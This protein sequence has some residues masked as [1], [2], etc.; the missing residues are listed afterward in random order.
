MKERLCRWHCGRRTSNHSGIC[1]ACWV[2][3]KPLRSFDAAGHAAWTVKKRAKMARG[4]S[5]ARVKAGQ[6]LAARLKA[7]AMAPVLK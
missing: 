5:P 7:R 2:L 6:T 1:D 4:K 3:S